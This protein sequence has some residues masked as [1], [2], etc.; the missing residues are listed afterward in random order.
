[1]KPSSVEYASLHIQQLICEQTKNQ[2]ILGLT[3]QSAGNKAQNSTVE[4]G[5]TKPNQIKNLPIQTQNIENLYTAL[6][7][8]S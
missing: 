3:G 5:C 2:A 7:S 1:M 8:E 6:L 4:S